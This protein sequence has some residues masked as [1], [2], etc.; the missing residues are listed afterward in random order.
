MA[1]T[2]EVYPLG[3]QTSLVTI[4]TPPMPAGGASPR[5]R[6]FVIDVSGSMSAPAIVQVAGGA[7]EETGRT[8]LEVVCDAVIAAIATLG[9]RD[10][11]AIVSFSDA[12][13]VRLAETAMTAEG[14]ERARAV[15]KALRP[16]GSTHLW[17]GLEKGMDLVRTALLGGSTMAAC[18]SVDLLTDGLPNVDPPNMAGFVPSL[19]D[20]FE[21]HAMRPLINCL[22]FGSNIQQEVLDELAREGGGLFSFIPSP[23]MVATNFVNS[24]AAFGAAAAASP[25]LRHSCSATSPGTPLPGLSLGLLPYGSRL[26][27]LVDLPAGVARSSLGLLGATAGGGLVMASERNPDAATGSAAC[28]AQWRGRVVAGLRSMKR[29]GQLG[30]L[31]GALAL[32]RSLSEGMRAEPREHLDAAASAGLTCLLGDIEGQVAISLSRAEYF[33]G[34]GSAYLLSLARAHELQLCANFKDPGLQGY[35]T[36]VFKSLQT[37]AGTVFRAALAAAAADHAPHSPS[38]GAA[39]GA[40]GSGGAGGAGAQHH[41]TATHGHHGHGGHT[42]AHPPPT[43]PARAAAAAALFDPAGGCVHGDGRVLL[44]D[45]ASTAAVSALT[46]GTLVAAAEPAG[47]VGRVTHIVRTRVEP[48]VACVALKGGLIATAWH[49]VKVGG[50]WVFPARAPAEAVASAGVAAMYPSA[51]YVYSVAIEAVE[52]SSGSASASAAPYG[53]IVDGVPVIT[54]GHGVTGHAVLSHAFYGTPAVLRA[55]E[56]VQAW[57]QAR[58]IAYDTFALGEGQWRWNNNEATGAVSIVYCGRPEE[59]GMPL[60]LAQG[61]SCYS[62]PAGAAAGGLVGQAH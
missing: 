7:K 2:L 26:S 1:A 28:L 10:G 54:L 39:G 46:V 36:P 32:V 22:G 53:L 19:R 57:C 11:A 21:Q 6:V 56:R 17:D 48:G 8:I 52:G 59:A 31:A 18:A 50:E 24:A 43:V 33:T 62:L 23:D 30:D 13:H 15:L 5:L 47:A 9:P 29:M 20:Y 40:G 34:W 35:A 25:S 45:G 60:G 14:K 44:A 27:F 37:T 55:L 58:G 12:A 61:S 4:A 41:H 16:G 51:P 49:P 38:G 42:Q 3:A